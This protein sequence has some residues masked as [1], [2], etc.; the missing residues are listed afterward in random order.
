MLAVPDLRTG[1][2]VVSASRDL[3][4]QIAPMV[5]QLDEDPA[6]VQ[7]VHVFSVENTDPQVV[8]DILNGMF[9]TQNTR[10]RTTQR[11]TGQA[12]NQLNN[13]ANTT[14]NQQ[15]TT[16]GNTGFGGSTSRT[17]R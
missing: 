9:Q 4:A 1:S 6:R 13:R 10:N 5:E 16:G 12:G 2:V 8:E 11:N 7:K 15:R 17:G 14:Q 3:M